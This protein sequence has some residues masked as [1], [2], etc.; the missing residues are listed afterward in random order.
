MLIS[1]QQQM[2]S[3]SRIGECE[4]TF[5]RGTLTH[6]GVKLPAGKRVSKALF[7]KTFFKKNTAI[8]FTARAAAWS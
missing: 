2:L 3:G 6:S 8:H 1:L 4:C 7:A 5:F